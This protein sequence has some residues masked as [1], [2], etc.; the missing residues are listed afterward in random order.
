MKR[1]GIYERALIVVASDH[2]Y[3]DY[4]QPRRSDGGGYEGALV[5]AKGHSSWTASRYWPMLMIKPPHAEGSLKFSDRPASLVDIAPTVYDVTGLSGCKNNPCDGESLLVERNKNS[6]HRR[7][8]FYIGGKENINSRYDSTEIYSAMDIEGNYVDGIANA[9]RNISLMNS[10]VECNEPLLFTR[11]SGYFASGL[12][13]ASRWGRRTAGK[14]TT[15]LFNLDTTTCEEFELTLEL[16]SFFSE[17]EPN[18][19]A[20]V[21]LNDEKNW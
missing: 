18:H 5:N 11:E 6:R 13:G 14:E 21:F 16:K 17:Q 3:P 12:S 15:L 4:L 9:I 19:A 20:A 7:A 8:I 10:F 1:L 2:G